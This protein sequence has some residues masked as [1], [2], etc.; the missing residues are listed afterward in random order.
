MRGEGAGDKPRRLDSQGKVIGE[1]A[2]E[3]V[4]KEGNE[5][6]DPEH[7]TLLNFQEVLDNIDSDLEPGSHFWSDI[8]SSD[9]ESE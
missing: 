7:S 9:E 2:I 5:I 3:V 8:E 4:D 1:V 6:G